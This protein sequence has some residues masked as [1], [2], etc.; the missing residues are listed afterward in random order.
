MH[1][2]PMVW[3]S[4]LIATALGLV[5]PQFAWILA[6]PPWAMQF[7]VVLVSGPIVL[8]IN[9]H[10]KRWLN[11]RWPDRNKRKSGDTGE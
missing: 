3:T 11:K 9:H 5:A 2:S 10:V 1:E 7:A 6:L 4:S 8:I